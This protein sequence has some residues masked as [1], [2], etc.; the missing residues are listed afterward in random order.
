MTTHD[1]QFQDDM[2]RAL[3]IFVEAMKEKSPHDFQ[4]FT[5]YPID[6]IIELFST[7]FAVH[8]FIDKDIL[9]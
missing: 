8:R 6:E 1:Q 7:A 3:Y 9:L 4:E 5:G 2:E